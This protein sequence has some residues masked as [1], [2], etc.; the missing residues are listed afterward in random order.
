[1]NKPTKN[2]IKFVVF[3]DQQLN[4]ILLSTRE[5]FDLRNYTNKN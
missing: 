4:P 5:K 3:I 1:M 2:D